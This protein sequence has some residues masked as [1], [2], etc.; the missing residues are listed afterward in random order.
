MKK[1]KYLCVCAGG[2]VRSH[3]LAYYLKSKGHAAIPIGTDHFGADELIGLVEW[4]DVIYTVDRPQYDMML[5]RIPE[6]HRSKVINLPIG[7]DRW[8]PRIPSDLVELCKNLCCEVS[9]EP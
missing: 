3:A 4:A 7:R 9:D 5:S 8:G 1:R 2:N 6:E